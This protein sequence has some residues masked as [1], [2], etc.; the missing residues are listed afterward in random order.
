MRRRV[1][2]ACALT[3]LAAVGGTAI[4]QNPSAITERKALLKE[5]GDA[6]FRPIGAMLR[7]EAPYD[8]AL[9]ATSLAAMQRNVPRIAQLFPADSQTGDTSALPAIWQNRTDFDARWQ[10][11]ATEA[12]AAGPRITDVNSLRA[13]FGPLLRDNCVAC[14]DRYRRS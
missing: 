3:T 12:A 13:V 11:L 2:I 4:A 8:A 5:M 9:V 10:R 14:H 6:T 1:A 7:G